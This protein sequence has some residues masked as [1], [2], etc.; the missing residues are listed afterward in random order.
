MIAYTLLSLRSFH[1]RTI[2]ISNQVCSNIVN[3]KSLR[4]KNIFEQSL[5]TAKS[6]AS[7][8]LEVF[9]NSL[10]RSTKVDKPGE[11]AVKNSS[12]VSVLTKLNEIPVLIEAKIKE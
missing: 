3:S 12:S 10:L 4:D 9:S 2:K 5:F 8:K 11:D 6:I 7:S 1:R